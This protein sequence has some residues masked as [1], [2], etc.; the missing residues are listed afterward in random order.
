MPVSSVNNTNTLL[1]EIH[2]RRTNCLP[3]L[4]VCLRQYLSVTSG[5]L[6]RTE[7]SFVVK[8]G[9]VQRTAVAL[10]GFAASGMLD[11]FLILDM[12][13]L[14]RSV[15]P[16]SAAIPSSTVSAGSASPCSWFRCTHYEL[17]AHFAR[18]APLAP[19]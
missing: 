11:A 1:A 13:N 5:I 8:G 10:I 3:V 18:L 16:P 9:C 15:Y 6:K 19:A 17:S 14:R 4:L 12:R 7:S 2:T